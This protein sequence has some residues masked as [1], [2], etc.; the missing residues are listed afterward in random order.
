MT[1]QFTLSR[2]AML[3]SALGLAA[4]A[5]APAGAMRD[6]IPPISG[7]SLN[8]AAKHSGRRFGSAFAWAPPGADAGSF[9][10]PEYAALLERDCGILVPENE[11]KWQAIRPGPDQY[12][13]AHMDAMVDY[14]V[15]HGF[16]LRGHTLLWHRPKWFPKWLNDYDFGSR[17]ATEAARILTDHIRTLIGRYGKHIVSFDVVNEAVD[18]A[19]GDLVETS[20]SKAMGGV[21]ET[22]D[23]AFRTAREAAPDTQLCYNDYMGWEPGNETHRAG[24]IK[25]LEGFRKRG[26]PVDALGV[27]SHL[28]MFTLDQATGLGPYQPKLWRDFLDAAVGM[29]YGLVITEFDVKDNALPADTAIRDKAV[30]EYARRYLDLM[31]EYPQLKDILAWGMTSRYSWLQ[32]FKPRDDGLRERCCPYGDDFQP[33]PLRAAMIGAFEGA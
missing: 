24:V 31:L 29:E 14:A 23:L 30:A 12:A 6:V 15:T 5:C 16:A 21:E 3:G 22:L 7:P 25:L 8:D 32:N 28:E 26:T 13:F 10:N 27:Q 19:T 18:P 1:D 20:L 4:G 2:R 9:N 33:L 11:L 17:P